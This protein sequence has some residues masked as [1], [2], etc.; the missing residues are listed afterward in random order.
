VTTPDTPISTARPGNP[1]IAEL[2]CSDSGCELGKPCAD[3]TDTMRAA[4][5]A[6]VRAIGPDATRPQ[7]PAHCQYLLDEVLLDLKGPRP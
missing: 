1:V 7:I 4:I 5:A 6:T 3:C 2:H